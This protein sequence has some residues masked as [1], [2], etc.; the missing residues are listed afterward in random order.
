MGARRLVVGASASPLA[1]AVPALRA[2]LQPLWVWRHP[3]AQRSPGPVA[4]AVLGPILA[5]VDLVLRVTHSRAAVLASR[6][7]LVQTLHAFCAH[8]I[9]QHRAGGRGARLHAQVELCQAT[10]VRRELDA[11]WPPMAT[12]YDQR[13]YSIPRTKS[14]SAL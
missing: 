7:H 3:A 13:T 11:W 6:V 2:P 10:G 12:R 14:L 5:A 4:V 9:S 8:S 1:A